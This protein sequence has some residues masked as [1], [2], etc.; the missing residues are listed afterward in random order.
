MEGFVIGMGEVL[1]DEL[2]GG[3]RLGGA[4][5]NFAYHVSQF[6]L[7]SRIVSAVGNDDA[8]R[9]LLAELDRR[10]V[11]GCIATVDRPTGSVTVSV[12]SGG[13]PRYDIREDVAWDSIPFTPALAGLASQTRAVC[14]GSLAQRSAVSRDTVKRFLDAM[15]DDGEH[16]K[17]CDINLRKPFCTAEI[18]EESLRMCNVLKINDEELFT[19]GQWLGWPAERLLAECPAIAERYGLRLLVLTCGAAGSYVFSQEE[20]SYLETPHVTVADTVGAGDS[21]TAALVAALLKGRPLAEAHRLAV[22]T[23]AYVC[24]QPGAM[25]PLPPELAAALR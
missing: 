10:G 18:A 6:G 22:Q 9:E 20:S 2:P 25:P 24:T 14:F 21:F 7:E 8:G 19:L 17:V 16:L 12:D 23:A 15:P 1:W 4:P 3:R 5:A 11:G 13:Q